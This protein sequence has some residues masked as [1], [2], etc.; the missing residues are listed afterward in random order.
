M[1]QTWQATAVLDE[2]SG[3][4]RSAK[5]TCVIGAEGKCKHAAAVLVHYLE[6]VHPPKPKS[7]YT[8]DV[9][10]TLPWGGPCLQEPLAPRPVRPRRQLPEFLTPSTR[11]FNKSH[12]RRPQ[13]APVPGHRAKRRRVSGSSV[14]DRATQQQRVRKVRFSDVVHMADC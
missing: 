5:C 6:I 10:L 8:F 13:S 3:Q 7:T 12:K 9:D 4:P 1:S 2:D 11:K 14:K